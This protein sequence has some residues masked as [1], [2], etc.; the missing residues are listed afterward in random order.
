MARADRLLRG[1]IKSRYLVT[2][3]TGETFEGVLLDADSDHLVLADSDAIS[4]NGDRLKVD[5]QLWLPRQ[6][7]S[8]LQ[9][10]R[11]V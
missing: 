6:N 3:D 4:P 2:I 9:L 11:K 1:Q 7:I 10:P 8:Y 5:G